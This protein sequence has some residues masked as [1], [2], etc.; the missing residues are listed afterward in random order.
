MPVLVNTQPGVS[1]LYGETAVA[2]AAGWDHSLALCSDGTV[3]AWGRNDHGQLGDNTTTNRLVPVPVN[4]NSGVSALYGKTVVAIAAGWGHS[5]ALCSDGRV[6][7]WGRNDYGQLGDNSTTS[8]LAPVAVNTNSGSALYG[9]TVVAIAAG[10]YDGLA[11]CSDGTVAAWGNNQFGSLGDNTTTQ[12][13]IPVAVSTDTNSALYGQAVV[14]IAAGVYHSLALCSNSTVAAW[15]NNRFG[16]LGDNTTSNRSVP[17]SVNTNSGVSAIYGRMV[18][19]I[20]TGQGHSLALCSDSTLAA[21]GDDSCGELGDNSYFTQR[22]APVTVN[23]TPLAASQRFTRVSGGSA[24]YDT[25]ALVA[26][27]P[28]SEIVLTGS[29]TLTSGWFQFGFSNTPGA[30]FS[31]LAATNPTVPLINWPSLTGLTEVSAGQFQFTDPQAANNARRFYRV[32]SP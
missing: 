22:N 18:A 11:L 17:V 3:V 30:F 16:Q 20:A 26:A 29:R 12:R 28:A 27:P 14:A 10:G 13:S 15:G 32:R 5:L 21:W 8:R 2:I 19:A 31:V 23:S 6:V 4:T 24:A 9:K 7:A 1:A 25:L